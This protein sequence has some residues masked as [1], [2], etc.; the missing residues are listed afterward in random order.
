MGNPIKPDMTAAAATA[1]LS[2]DAIDEATSEE[3][4]VKSMPSDSEDDT[5]MV[6][7]SG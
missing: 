1:A 2:T 4:A 5:G 6:P 3:L 7:P